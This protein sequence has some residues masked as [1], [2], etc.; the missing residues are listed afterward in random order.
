MRTSRNSI[1]AGLDFVAN[2]GPPVIMTHLFGY[3][4]IWHYSQV[5]TAVDSNLSNI[6][7]SSRAQVRILLVSLFTPFTTNVLV[8]D[9]LGLL[10]ELYVLPICVDPVDR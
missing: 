2:R 1:C 9:H 5:V 3:L 10:H 7:S 8:N 4:L 6:N